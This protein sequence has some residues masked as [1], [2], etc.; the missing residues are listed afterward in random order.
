MAAK[1]RTRAKKRFGTSKAAKERARRQAMVK[2]KLLSK[3]DLRTAEL[4][5]QGVP[6]DRWYFD[7]KLARIEKAFFKVAAIED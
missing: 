1:K 3:M 7:K 6:M 2:T 5:A 4:R